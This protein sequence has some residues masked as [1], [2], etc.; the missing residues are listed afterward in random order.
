MHFL[1][2]AEDDAV[3]IITVR[4]YTVQT[5]ICQS[6]RCYLNTRLYMKAPCCNELRAYTHPLREAPTP[7]YSAG[8][9][10]NGRKAPAIKKIAYALGIHGKTVYT[11]NRNIVY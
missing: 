9:I 4:E 10:S 11:Y 6:L 1:P 2:P 3:G 8:K 5:A 7:R